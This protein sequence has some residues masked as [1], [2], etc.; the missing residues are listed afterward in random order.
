MNFISSDTYKNM[1]QALAGELMG[2]TKYALYA[3]KAYDDGYVQIGDIFSETSGN[4]RE[5]AEVLMKLINGGS[6]PDTLNNLKESYMGENGEWTNTYMGF[7]DTAERE[8]FSDIAELFRNI[9]S[10]ERHHDYRFR[11]LAD[12]IENENV[13]CRDENSLWVCLNCGFLYEGMCAPD[14]VCP[15]CGVHRGY[16]KLN[17]EDY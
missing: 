15:L 12:N 11:N 6:L 2:S 17:C 7:A 16:Y 13:L 3:G 14:D 8:G 4:E 10:V 5:H 1:M 9:A